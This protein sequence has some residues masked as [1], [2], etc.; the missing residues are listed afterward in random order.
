MGRAGI[1][2]AAVPHS[3]PMAG[4]CRRYG[5]PRR[6]VIGSRD[7]WGA[8]RFAPSFR[9]VPMVLPPG[10]TRAA[11]I[12]LHS[13]DER[14]RKLADAV[15]QGGP[16]RARHHRDGAAEAADVS[17]EVVA[18]PRPAIRPDLSASVGQ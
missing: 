1:G 6:R 10:G 5:S 18:L 3:E 2:V 11:L 16:R 12:Y 15:G 13:S 4:S 17:A 9:Q 7:R 8:P 14:R